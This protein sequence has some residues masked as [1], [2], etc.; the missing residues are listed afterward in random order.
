MKE[1]I[2]ISLRRKHTLDNFIGKHPTFTTLVQKL[3]T[4]AD[5]PVS[6]LLTGETGTGKGVCAELIHQYSDR[7]KG[8][9]IPYNCGAGP[10]SLFE[11]QL[12]GHVK[13]AFTGANRDRPGLVEEAHAGILFLDEIN[14]LSPGS[15]VKLNH[16]LETGYLRRVGENRLRRSDARIIAATNV[17]LHN[18]VK[19]R[20]FREDLY[21]RLAEY[22][23]YVPPLR[24]RKTD[25]PLLIDYFLKKNIHLNP[26]GRIKFTSKALKKLTEY[27]WPGNIRE[28]ENITKRCIIDASRTIVDDV[29]L[30]NADDPLSPIYSESLQ[31][32]PWKEAKKQVVT[33]FEK[34][35]LQGLLRR[36]HGT[37][38]QCARHAGVQPPDFWKLMRKY[39]LKA[40][41]FR[42]QIL[43]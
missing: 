17:D 37:V 2:L 19:E 21:F 10:E 40:Q 29:S 33:T 18:E 35:Y 20:H 41:N 31:A 36:Y 43:S 3:K 39:A 7:F 42:S 25:I 14:S 12:F 16:F 4:I 27:H 22:E 32:L 6:V 5:K 9:F 28:L 30:P 26:L 34:S 1:D 15:Q 8:P 11:S 23:L 38:A 13:G 24:S